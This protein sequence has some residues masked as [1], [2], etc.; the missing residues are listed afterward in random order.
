MLP[1]CKVYAEQRAEKRKLRFNPMPWY[2]DR[3]VW[4]ERKM[5][6]MTEFKMQPDGQG[7]LLQAQYVTNTYWYLVD[8]RK[9]I[10]N[11]RNN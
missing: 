6:N 9:P 4:T 1:W 11:G 2:L 3:R 5:I 7:P 10:I 8:I